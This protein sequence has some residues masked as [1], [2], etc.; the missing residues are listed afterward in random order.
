MRGVQ[1]SSP[2]EDL[3]ELRLAEQQIAPDLATFVR[4]RRTGRPVWTWREL[5]DEIHSR[6]GI[7]VSREWLR[8]R[9]AEQAA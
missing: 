3:I 5:S 8:V 6:T 1:S 9:F 7:R 4:E 2:T